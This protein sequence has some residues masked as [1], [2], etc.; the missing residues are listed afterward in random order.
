M[1]WFKHMA[2]ASNDDF[3]EWIE[4]EYGLEGYARWWKILETI[5]LSMEKDRSN[6]SATHTWQKW[7]IILKGKRSQLL[8]FLSAIA[9]QGRIEV[10]SSDNILE[11][12]CVKLLKMRDEYSK[13]S[14]H[15]PDTL[16]TVDKD[17][18]KDKDKKASVVSKPK[19]DFDFD[20]MAF[21]GI[22]EDMIAV[23]RKA[24]PAIDIIK[25]INAAATWLNA[26]PKNRKSNYPKFLVNWFSRAQD[27]APG[28]NQSSLFSR[29]Q[30]TRSGAKTL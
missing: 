28:T 21:I 5:A 11:I 24:Y 23:W 4:Q 26:N 17:K 19:I 8:T 16:L 29:S 18:D 30:P 20:L 15:T 6:P 14:R 25:E 3:I 2:N 22:P 10:K 12:K 1:K 9:L 27:K 13:K 7:Q